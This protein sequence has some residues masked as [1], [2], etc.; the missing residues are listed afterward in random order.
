MTCVI[1]IVGAATG[2]TTKHDGAYLV[3]CDVDWEG[4]IGA[5][6]S[7]KLR[8]CAMRFDDVGEAMEFWRRQSTVMP[9]RP[10][11]KPNRP[12]TAFTIE[13]LRDGAEPL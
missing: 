9:F 4:G 11:G 6:I 13:I 2:V 8:G 1:H 5:V 3:D 10:D 7:T 12:L